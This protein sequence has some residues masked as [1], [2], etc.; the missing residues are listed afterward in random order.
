MMDSSQ[1]RAVGRVAIRLSFALMAVVLVTALAPSAAGAAIE[2]RGSDEQAALLGTIK[3]GKCGL[4]GKKANRRF[5]AVAKSTDGAYELSVVV[6]E[7]HGYRRSYSFFYGA[8]EPGSFY[9]RGPDD[10]Y[11]NLFPIPGTPPGV[12]GGGG[13]AF[14]NKGR[15]MSLGFAPAGNRDFSRGVVIAGAMKCK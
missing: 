11:S 13:I 5:R 12:V 6:S 2:I 15:R 10:D 4:K 3:K 1:P 8:S 7:W 9:L 14:G